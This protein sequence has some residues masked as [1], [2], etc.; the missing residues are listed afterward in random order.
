M[1]ND[2]KD[3]VNIE[4]DRCGIGLLDVRI[5]DKDAD[6]DFTF[7]VKCDYCGGRSKEHTFHGLLQHAGTQWSDVIDIDADEDSG[8]IT[9]YTKKVTGVR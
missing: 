4:C 3:I 1:K 5:A 2:T 9:F 6:I 8:I 7:I